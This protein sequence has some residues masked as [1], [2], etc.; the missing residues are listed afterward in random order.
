MKR[1]VWVAP[2]GKRGLKRKI[3]WR[4]WKLFI[5]FRLSKQDIREELGISKMSVER[6]LIKYGC[7]NENGENRRHYCPRCKFVVRCFIDEESGATC[8]E[9]CG[10]SFSDY[11]G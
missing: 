8:C 5:L 6:H 7:L 3:N 10:Y 11:K 9:Q 4:V 2:T 1:E